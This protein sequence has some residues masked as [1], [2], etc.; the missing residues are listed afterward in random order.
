MI[1]DG[2]TLGLAILFGALLLGLLFL[3]VM[4]GDRGR[5]SDDREP[6][7]R[8]RRGNIWALKVGPG[9][10]HEGYIHDEAAGQ[11]E[12]HQNPA[13]VEETRWWL[14]FS[15]SVEV[16]YYPLTING[17]LTPDIDA[18]QKRVDAGRREGADV[19]LV[20]LD[21]ELERQVIVRENAGQLAAGVPARQLTHRIDGKRR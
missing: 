3:H 14:L 2:L 20:T 17:R 16:S 19:D 9:T 10:P 8:D 4:S 5:Q 6:Y 13:V 7:F 1:D 18:I 12:P 15:Y 21:K 11:A